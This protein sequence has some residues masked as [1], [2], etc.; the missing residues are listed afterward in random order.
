MIPEVLCYQYLLF[1]LGSYHSL[2]NSYLSIALDIDAGQVFCIC[3]VDG[4]YLLN[5]L[6][7]QM[8]WGD[9]A[10]EKGIHRI[11]GP[12]GE[13]GNLDQTLIETASEI[14]RLKFLKFRLERGCGRTD[15]KDRQI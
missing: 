12:A 1:R 6:Y 2:Y 7:R 4:I 5:Y 10:T 14:G 13:L 11:I 15:K 9:L 8:N 3:G